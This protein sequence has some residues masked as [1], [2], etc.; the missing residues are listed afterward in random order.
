MI[1]STVNYNYK[2]KTPTYDPAKGHNSNFDLDPLY[3]PQ[4]LPLDGH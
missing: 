1:S 4:K 2:D 3:F